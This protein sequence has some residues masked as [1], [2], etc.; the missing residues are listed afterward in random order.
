MF[1]QM[2]KWTVIISIW[3][4]YKRHLT[5]TLVLLLVL[6]LISQFHKDFIEFHS[7]TQTPYLAISYVVKWLAYLVCIL[8]YGFMIKKVNANTRFDSTLHSMMA[9]KPDSAVSKKAPAQKEEDAFA[10][11]R[12]KKKLRSKADFIISDDAHQPNNKDGVEPNK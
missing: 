9:A 3:R 7:Q 4:K 6:F 11:L 12:T 10:H 2:L 1:N 8:V 5:I